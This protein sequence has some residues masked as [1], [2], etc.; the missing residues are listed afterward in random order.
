MDITTYLTEVVRHTTQLIGCPAINMSSASVVATYSLILSMSASS[1]MW[2]QMYV[3]D[4]L[5]KIWY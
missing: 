2:S 1:E 4:P 5:G 3:R